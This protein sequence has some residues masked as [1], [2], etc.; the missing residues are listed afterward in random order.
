MVVVNAVLFYNDHYWYII[1]KKIMLKL[2]RTRNQLIIGK[3]NKMKVMT[4]IR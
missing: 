1:L 4:R 2:Q 3:A